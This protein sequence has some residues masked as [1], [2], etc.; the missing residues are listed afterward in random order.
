MNIGQSLLAKKDGKIIECIVIEL[1][2]EDILLEDKE[3]KERLT[4]K[5]WEVRKLEIKNDL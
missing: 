3:T 1:F 4:R 2:S 5:Y